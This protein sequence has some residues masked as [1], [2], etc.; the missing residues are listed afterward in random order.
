MSNDLKHSKQ[1]IANIDAEAEKMD[2]RESSRITDEMIVTAKASPVDKLINF[3]RGRAVC[4][5][6]GSKGDDLSH[7]K[8][9]NRA[10]CF[11]KC[12]KSWDA[13][14]ILMERDGMSFVDAVKALQ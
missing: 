3:T 10:K 11:G 8:K 13:I 4:P 2:A 6:H 14:G 12:G 7:D 9:N 5:F 1:E